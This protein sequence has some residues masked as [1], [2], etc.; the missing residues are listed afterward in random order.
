MWLIKV[1]I[2]QEAPTSTS[3]SS[4]LYS[5]YK[6]IKIIILPGDIVN[7]SFKLRKYRH[8][9][10]WKKKWIYLVKIYKKLVILEKIR[11]Y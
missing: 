6:K 5:K 2:S 10:N 7:K 3:G 9:K 8:L 1:H 4:S 11:Y